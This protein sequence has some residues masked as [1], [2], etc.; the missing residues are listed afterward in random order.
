[1]TTKSIN[2]RNILLLIL[3]IA[4]S[5][6]IGVGIARANNASARD[7]VRSTDGRHLNELDRVADRDHLLRAE[8]LLAVRRVDAADAVQRTEVGDAGDLGSHSD[9]LVG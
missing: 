5:I 3:V 4:A 6:S 1:M 7:S 9:R 8:L 2:I